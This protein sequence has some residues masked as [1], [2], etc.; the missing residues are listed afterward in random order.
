MV[1]KGT[2]NYSPSSAGASETVNIWQWWCDGGKCP[3]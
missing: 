2:H 1:K 3:A